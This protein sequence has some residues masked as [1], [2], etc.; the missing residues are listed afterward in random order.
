MDFPDLFTILKVFIIEI[1]QNAFDI[2]S[3]L[4]GFDIFNWFINWN[5]KYQAQKTY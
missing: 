5:P 1:K 4:S 2:E 3:N